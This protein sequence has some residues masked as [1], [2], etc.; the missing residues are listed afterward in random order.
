MHQFGGG[1]EVWRCEAMVN[2]DNIMTQ[3][4][5]AIRYPCPRKRFETTL[6]GQ[7]AGVLRIVDST[8]LEDVSPG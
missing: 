6:L 5:R 4:N 7:V 8:L 3:D 2:D 1:P